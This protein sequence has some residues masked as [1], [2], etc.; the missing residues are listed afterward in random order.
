LPDRSQWWQQH[1][2][3]VDHAIAVIEE[4]ERSGVT[5]RTLALDI[6]DLQA[7]RVLLKPDLLGLPAIRGVV[8]A[9]GAVRGR[10]IEE[11]DAESVEETWHA[12]V[13]GALVLHELF[14]PGSIDEMVLFSSTA[15]LVTLPG[16]TAYAA[17]NTF[18]DALAAYRRALGADTTAIAWTV[19]RN[20]GMGRLTTDGLLSMQA[21][22]FGDITPTEAHQAWD[23]LHSTD[24]GYALVVR[25]TAPPPAGRRP[26]FEHIVDPQVE[27]SAAT[28]DAV[29]AVLLRD[30]PP[31]Q[32]FDAALAEIQGQVA[33]VTGLPLER[34]D[35]DRPFTDMGLDSV[36]SIAVRGRLQIGTGVELPAS[37][38]WTHTTPAALA[39]FMTATAASA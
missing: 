37:V 18:L 33:A 39:Q 8:H 35:P 1:D 38:M 21:Q 14:P 23:Y 16:G 15:P 10:L 7:A 3:A 19:W 34:V 4:L 17:A 36:M 25:P 11:L 2:E 20:M 30:L 32:V 5:V 9:A 26:L 12:K 28:S 24:D 31:E 13:H 6:A 22:G 27:N 29:A